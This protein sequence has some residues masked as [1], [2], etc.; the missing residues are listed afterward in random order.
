M[1]GDQDPLEPL[2]HK[3]ENCLK[4]NDGRR[5]LLSGLVS[6]PQSVQ[7]DTV[8]VEQG[9]PYSRA[10]ILTAGWAVSY[11]VLSDGRRQVVDLLLPG[12]FVGLQG[13]VFHEADHSLASIT[14]STIYWFEY[15]GMLEL[16]RRDPLLGMAVIW[17]RTGEESVL[18]ERLASLGQ[19]SARERMA[20]ILVE[21]WQ[22]L[23]LR[24]LGDMTRLPFP[25][26]QSLL[27]DLLGITNV[28]VNRT[29]TAMKKDGLVT[30]DRNMIELLDAEA[31]ITLGDFDSTYLHDKPM[32]A[33]TKKRIEQ[34]LG[35]N[36]PDDAIP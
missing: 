18:M 1:E 3:L 12:T 15:E 27:A 16:T 28:H 22:R 14:D 33:G 4:L 34:M 13:L 20:H 10:G 29:L 19:R 7:R 23:H 6:K 8:I 26:N 17:D 30:Y 24:G 32:A 21:L 2:F 36:R 9:L 5:A 25:V 11:K 31:L 35:K